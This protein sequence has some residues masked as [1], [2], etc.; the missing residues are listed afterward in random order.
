M[1]QIFDSCSHTET[2]PKRFDMESF[3]SKVLVVFVAGVVVSYLA[4]SYF[5]DGAGAI[6]TAICFYGALLYSLLEKF[7]TAYISKSDKTSTDSTE[8]KEEEEP[9]EKQ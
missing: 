6:F 2:A 9:E 7:V 8:K 4:G 5:N 3:L 1:S